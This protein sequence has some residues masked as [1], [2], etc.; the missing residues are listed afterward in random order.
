VPYAGLVALLFSGPVGVA[1]PSLTA[2]LLSLWDPAVLIVLQA[3]WLAM[4]VLTARSMVTGSV[5]SFHVNREQ[6]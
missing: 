6:I 1:K 5:L 2:G 3:T 4:F